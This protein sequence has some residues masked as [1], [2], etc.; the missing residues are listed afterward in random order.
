MVVLVTE[1]LYIPAC[2]WKMDYI[3]FT[4]CRRRVYKTLI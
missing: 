2:K 3:R 4:E 1:K